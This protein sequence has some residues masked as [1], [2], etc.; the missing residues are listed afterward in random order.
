MSSKPGRFSKPGWDF[1]DIGLE[2]EG[3]CRELQCLAKPNQ[4][5]HP[6]PSLSPSPIPPWDLPHQTGK[7]SQ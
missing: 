1:L 2:V 4:V 3:L 7:Q 5:H 6:S